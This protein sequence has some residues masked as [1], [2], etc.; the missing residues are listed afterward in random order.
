MYGT[1]QDTTIHTP[2][3]VVKGQSLTRAH[4]YIKGR[5]R[6]VIETYNRYKYV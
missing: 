3:T 6:Q 1:L 2:S 4:Q 5:K